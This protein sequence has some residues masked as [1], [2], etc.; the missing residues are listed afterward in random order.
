MVFERIRT[1]KPVLVLDY[2][3]AELVLVFSCF[4]PLLELSSTMVHSSATQ[5]WFC[6]LVD[7]HHTLTSLVTCCQAPLIDF[8]KYP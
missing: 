7:T 6:S 3:E 4:V 2:T 5:G 1:G 8:Q